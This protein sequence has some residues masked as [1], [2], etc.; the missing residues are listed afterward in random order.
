MT[1]VNEDAVRLI[2]R[3]IAQTSIENERRYSDLDAV[4]ALLSD[5]ATCWTDGG[6]VVSAARRV[7]VGSRKVARFLI[8]VTPTMPPTQSSLRGATEKLNLVSQMTAL[9]ASSRPRAMV[10]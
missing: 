10:V 6:G 1:H 4:M 3:T 8:A 7:I 2:L 9:I 5:D